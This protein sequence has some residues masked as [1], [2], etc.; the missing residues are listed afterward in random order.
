MYGV[1]K[2]QCLG[3]RPRFLTSILASLFGA[4]GWDMLQQVHSVQNIRRRWY[5]GGSSRMFSFC[6]HTLEASA[7]RR[8]LMHDTLRQEYWYR[9]Y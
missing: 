1:T 8:V 9:L 3:T 5:H 2:R 4:L 6:S 7:M